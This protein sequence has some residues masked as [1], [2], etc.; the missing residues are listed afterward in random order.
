[1]MIISSPLTRAAVTPLDAANNYPINSISLPVISS[2]FGSTMV[3]SF[4]MA[5]NF[6]AGPQSVHVVGGEIGGYW[7]TDVPYTDYYGRVEYVDFSLYPDGNIDPEIA[8]DLPEKAGGGDL[9]AIYT[10]WN[11]NPLVIKKDSS[12]ILQFNY[13]L[14]L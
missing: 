13:Q 2:A 6:S 8:L 4:E 14:S 10:I 12:E 7:Q 3:F 1:M 9:R 11:E 5:D